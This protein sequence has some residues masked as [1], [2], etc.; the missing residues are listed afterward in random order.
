[1]HGHGTERDGLWRFRDAEDHARILDREKSFWHINV[2]KNR[3]DKGGNRDKK[4]DSAE[5]KDNF[6][7]ASVKRNDRIECVFGCAVEPR[8]IFFSLMTEELGAHH[9]RERKR[10]DRG[11][12]NRYRQSDGKFT[13]ETTDD[14]AHKQERN[15]HC[16]KGDGQRENREADLL[17]AFEGG[18]QRR[19]ALLDEAGDVFDHDDGVVYDK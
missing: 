3:A 7:R 10:N 9:R 6:Q 14:I 4:S 11:N 16:D 8:F 18:L 2:E 12:E 19:F 13:E 5:L 15:Q 17:G 1:M